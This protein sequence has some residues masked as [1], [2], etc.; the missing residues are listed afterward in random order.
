MF[1]TLA[2]SFHHLKVEERIERDLSLLEM[3]KADDAAE[4]GEVSAARYHILLLRPSTELWPTVQ[5]SH[6]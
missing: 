1:L 6:A 3:D 5:G 2:P 4:A